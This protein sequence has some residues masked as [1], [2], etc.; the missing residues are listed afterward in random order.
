MVQDLVAG[1]E[2]AVYEISGV[3]PI[4][5][6]RA[7]SSLQE[8]RELNFDLVFCSNGLEHV[9]SA[10]AIIDQIREIG[11][12][13]KLAYIEVPN[14]SPFDGSTLLK[15]IA[16]IGILCLRRPTI[17]LALLRPRMLYWTH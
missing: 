5:G 13:G 6:V 11:G 4:P 3:T 8:C 2:G 9:G 12:P 15:R 10:R 7:T 1:A 14:E 16:Q 17:G